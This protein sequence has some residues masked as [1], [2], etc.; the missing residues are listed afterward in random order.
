MAELRLSARHLQQHVAK[1]VDHLNLARW[2]TPHSRPRLG[3]LLLGALLVLSCL[4]LWTADRMSSALVAVSPA[5]AMFPGLGIPGLSNLTTA[6]PHIPPKIWQIFLDYSPSAIEPYPIHSWV[7]KS[8]SHSYTILDAD[9]ALAVVS[10]LAA[11]PGYAHALPLFNAMS[12]RVLR[13]DFLRYLLLLMEGGAYSDIDT[14]MVRPL[15]RWVPG[16]FKDRT[17]LVVG[18][19]ADMSPPIVG[20]TYEVQ[21]CQWT[22]AGAPDH[23]ALW[24]MVDRILAKVQSRVEA[25]PN[26]D[27]DINYSDHDVLDITG[28]AGWTEVIMAHLST[29]TGTE[30]TWHNLTGMREPRLYGDT[31]VLPID[32]FA[33]GVPHSNASLINTEYTMVRHAFRGAWKNGQG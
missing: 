7:S 29:V 22:L 30:M 17:R 12:R 11:I 32:G 28:P 9:G 20:T 23:P 27:Q 19:E 6:L 5:R 4:Y 1:Y 18:L 8:P 24:A 14:E 3:G 16:N 10:Q 15:H 21:F 2:V 26:P 13:A 33:T 31:L 25:Y